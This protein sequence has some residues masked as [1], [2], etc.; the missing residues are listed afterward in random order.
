MRTRPGADIGAIMVG[1]RGDSGLVPRVECTRETEVVRER[2]RVFGLSVLVVGPERRTWCLY[3][4][5][6]G[7]GRAVG[8][9]VVWWAV[10]AGCC[11]LWKGIDA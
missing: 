9:M 3:R 11:G 4:E 6:A 1:S 10:G 2:T 8:G 7:W 5:A